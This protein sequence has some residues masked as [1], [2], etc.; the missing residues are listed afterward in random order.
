MDGT[1]FPW[2]LS[3]LSGVWRAEEGDGRRGG[4]KNC[5][6]GAVA[7]DVEGRT[8]A[9][10]PAGGRLSGRHP[11]DQA[12]DRDVR[13]RNADG[14]IAW[15]RLF[16]PWLQEIAAAYP[17]HAETDLTALADGMFGVTSAGLILS[18]TLNDPKAVSSQVMLYRESIRMTFAPR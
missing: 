4:R 7:A 6:D 2:H 12:F 8:P 5:T 9:Q 15:L 17:P 16:L 14:L 11:Q 3:R 18:K 1:G 10:P 13:Q